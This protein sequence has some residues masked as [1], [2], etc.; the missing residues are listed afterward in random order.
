MDESRTTDRFAPAEAALGRI[1]A[2]ATVASALI[3]L[4]G[5][6]LYLRGHGHDAAN[7]TAYQPQPSELSLLGAIFKGAAR[8][9]P[10]A[11]M[12]LGV[13]VLVLTPV[14]RVVFSMILFALRRDAMYTIIT[15][16]VLAVLLA[17]LLGGVA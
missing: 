9:E 3:V 8:A 6:I 14:A 16:A 1:V 7:F 10:A 17:G 5:G 11:L 15:L 2:L 13:L 12:Q 4:I